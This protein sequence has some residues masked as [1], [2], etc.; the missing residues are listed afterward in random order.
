M[1]AGVPK[2]IPLAWQGWI[3]DYLLAQA[4]VGRPKTTLGT[5]KSH[6]ARLA[7]EL[8]K[9]PDQVTPRQL[10][11]WFGQ[12]THWSNET[13]RGYRN[14]I[15]SFYLW[16]YRVGH[17]P[18][19]ALAD[20]IPSVRPTKPV[21]RP[22]P[23]NVW[24]RAVLAADVRVELMLKLAACGLRRGEVALVRTDDL[25]WGAGGALLLVHGKGAKKRVI[26][27][28]DE[29]AEMIARG[30][31]GHSPGHGRSGWLFPGAEDGHLSARWV[32]RLCGRVM[33]GIWTMHS[34]RHR[35]AAKAFRGTR[36][37][38]AVQKI[39]G[40][41]SVATTEIYTPVDDDEVRAAM[42]AAVA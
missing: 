14:T 37:L 24:A 40:H 5:R 23:E 12:Q 20:A 22:A 42:R 30:P 35:C 6:L 32:G 3:D 9:P 26:P 8:R 29:L 17:L 33:P 4:A 18:T 7:R 34:L 19:P 2:V 21:P 36:N 41:E 39:L 16:A 25:S 38:R 15:R 13:R 11:R 28:D 27:V 31:G 1:N 10:E